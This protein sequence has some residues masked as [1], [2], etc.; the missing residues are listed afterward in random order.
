MVALLVPVTTDFSASVLNNITEIRFTGAAPATATFANT[1]FDNIAILDAVQL[2]GGASTDNIVVNGGS[3]D[4][5]G[6]TFSGWTAGTD[7]ITLNG[8]AGADTIE[9]SSARDTINGNGSSDV[10]TVGGAGN[11]GDTLNGGGGNDAFVYRA[12]ASGGI[13]DTINGGSG[14]AD[15]ILLLDAGT[16]DF[17]A[18]TISTVERLNFGVSVQTA[19]LLGSQ[20][21]GATALLTVNAT[22]AV[23]NLEV[24][25]SAIDFSTVTFNA[26]DSASDLVTLTG[27]AG[28]D[29]I[30]G[31]SQADTIIGGLDGDVLVGGDGDDTFRYT[32]QAD[33][34]GTET[35]DG[36][37]G[38]NDR[39]FVEG[40]G[41]TFFNDDAISGIE[42]VFLEG[43][44]TGAYFDASQLGAGAISTIESGTGNVIFFASGSAIDLSGISFVNWSSGLDSINI[45]GGTGADVLTGSQFA[46][47][48]SG[49]GGA[50]AMSGGDGDDSFAFT[51]PAIDPGLSIDGG[52][53]TGDYILA[54]INASGTLDFS[55]TSISGVE[56]VLFYAGSKTIIF[57]SAQIGGSSDLLQV[58]GGSGVDVLRVDGA[59][60]DLASLAFTDWTAGTDSVD[61]NGTSGSDVITGSSQADTIEGFAGADTLDG[62]LGADAM[63]GGAQND[64]YYVDSSGDTVTELLNEGYDTVNTTLASY[65]LGDNFE[66]VNSNG[67]ANFVGTGNALGNRFQSLGG[68]DRFVDV[69]G[70]GDIFS[71]GNGTDTVDF[72]TSATG[73]ILDF[74]TNVHAGAALGDS[75]SSIEKY[76]GSTSAADTMTAGGVGRVIYAG[77]GGNDALTGGVKNDQLLGGADNDTLIGNGDRD[78]LDGGTGNDTMTGGTEGD[79]FVFVDAAFGQDTITDFVDGSDS[80]KVFSAVADDIADFAIANN[81][82]TTVTLT[83]IADNTNTITIQG[84]APITITGADFVFY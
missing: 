25:G 4:A 50:D 79:V 72:R 11:Q 28:A 42:R 45:I 19:R 26:W 1:Q 37:N 84:A 15:R 48:F 3:V 12:I 6:W 16:Y 43:S 21:G 38:A 14:V 71:G 80:F 40:I 64:V 47:Q 75:Y 74:T 27:T 9:G 30:T 22:A 62:G 66:R 70:G 73:A 10:I 46:E 58:Y 41:L 17:S 63:A 8:T 69:L 53:G 82:T 35:V 13:T 83:L 57:N 2:T 36:G 32:G 49:N 39:I 78:S 61:I 29:T 76:L 67:T 59:A 18:A 77:Y 23:N 55:P 31:S 81:G 44:N 5:S 68:D 24:S 54:T 34:L 20:I 33:T 51:T 65:T 52:G 60:T 56:A 7:T